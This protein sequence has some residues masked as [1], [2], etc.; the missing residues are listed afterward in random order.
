[1]CV[2]ER[3]DKLRYSGDSTHSCLRHVWRDRKPHQPAAVVRRTQQMQSLGRRQASSATHCE[4]RVVRSERCGVVRPT[5]PIVAICQSFFSLRRRLFPHDNLRRRSTLKWTKK[6]WSA[7]DTDRHRRAQRELCARQSIGGPFQTEHNTGDG[8][9]KL[10]QSNLK[11]KA[12]LARWE[13]H[14]TPFCIAN[15]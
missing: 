11:L 9:L 10:D 5:L 6:P 14:E 13:C 7:K 4:A 8:P 12:G 3:A 15:P 2:R 1:M